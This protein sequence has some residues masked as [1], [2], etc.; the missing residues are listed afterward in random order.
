MNNNILILGKTRSEHDHFLRQVIDR[1]AKTGL[2]LNRAK[3]SLAISSVNLLGVVV[4]VGGISPDLEK[5]AGIQ[6]MNPH[7]DVTGVRRLLGLVNHIGH[8]LLLVSEFS[9]R[10]HSPRKLDL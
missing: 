8:F 4:T 10:I 9:R 7:E 6:A 5:V 1:L 3:C 2:M